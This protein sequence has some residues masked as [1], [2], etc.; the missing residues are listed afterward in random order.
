MNID[1]TAFEAN[2]DGLVG[3]TH[4]YAGLAKGNAASAR[5]ATRRSDPRAAALQGLEKM[6]RLSERGIAQG[7]LPPQERPHMATLRA[8][9]FRGRDAE[10][11]RLARRDAPGLLAAVSS[12]SAMWS[13]NAATV[14]PAP[15]TADGRVHF[16]PANLASHLHRSLEP[17]TTAAALRATFPDAGHFVH[18]APLPA[19]PETADEGAANHTRICAEIGAP[20]LELFVY[21]RDADPAEPTAREPAR[22][23]RAASEAVAR[24]HQLSPDRLLLARQHPEAIEAGA[25]HNDVVAVGHRELLLYHEQAFVDAGSIHTWIA[26][27]LEALCTPVFIEVPRKR[28]SLE[29][30]VATYLFNSQILSLADGRMLIACAQECREHEHV[31]AWL[32]EQVSD[33]RNPLAEI[34]VFDLRQSMN[35]GGGPACLRLRVV[36]DA[37]SRAAVNPRSWFTPEL[38][39]A[40]RE[41]I[42]RGY[43]DRLVLDDLADPQLL[44][45]S[46]TV[47]DRITQL[48]GLGSLY[49]FQR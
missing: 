8:L 6:R 15:D 22:Q 46:R 9:G 27:G 43:R 33:P 48:L 17:A 32:N 31:W 11:L 39:T 19:A 7:I 47:L 34:E 10:V 4:C 18:H 29:E 26:R 28:I 3:P 49:E 21:G 44:D 30:A 25:F 13:A 1:V 42:E 24:L 16:T 38:H 23:S 45:E 35:N 14:S 40:L 37:R 41:L 12:A 36:L 5:N 20:G 2:F